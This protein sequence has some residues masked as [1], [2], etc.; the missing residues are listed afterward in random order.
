MASVSVRAVLTAT[1]PLLLLLT[2]TPTRPACLPVLSVSEL[3]GFAVRRHPVGGFGI[4]AY[5]NDSFHT[6]GWPDV[7]P[8]SEIFTM[9]DAIAEAER[10]SVKY[11]VSYMWDDE[12][13]AEQAS[14]L[15]ARLHVTEL[16]SDYDADTDNAPVA[17][18]E[19][20]PE[21]EIDPK[22]G[23]MR[24]VKFSE[25]VGFVKPVEPMEPGTE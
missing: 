20:L 12:I 9:N 18:P 14:N 24:F 2:A 16:D 7:N 15:S 19:P 13:W 4:V 21:A 11:D 25:S 8:D 5:T 6:S 3:G 17:V 1:S 22:T 10:L 23:T